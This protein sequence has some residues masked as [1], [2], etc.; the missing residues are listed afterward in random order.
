MGGRMAVSSGR[1]VSAESREVVRVD[2]SAGSELSIVEGGCVANLL[3]G[4]NLRLS[5]KNHQASRAI[6][7]KPSPNLEAGAKPDTD[8]SVQSTP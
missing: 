3:D 1:T 8:D 5:K 7:P 4:L 2:K 6:V